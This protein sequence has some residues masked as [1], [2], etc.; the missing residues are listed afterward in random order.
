[1][2]V[3]RAHV[4]VGAAGAGFGEEHPGADAGPAGGEGDGAE[5]GVDEEGAGGVVPVGFGLGAMGARP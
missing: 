3:P 5:F 4:E 1:V 2:I